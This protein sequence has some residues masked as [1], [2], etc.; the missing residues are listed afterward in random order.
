MNISSSSL[1]KLYLF[2][3]DAKTFFKLSHS[4]NILQNEFPNIEIEKHNIAAWNEKTDLI[5][6]KKSSRGSTLINAE[7]KVNIS[8]RSKIVTVK[9]DSLDNVINGRSVDYIKY[10]VEGAEAE[11]LEGS[12]KTILAHSPILCISLYHRPGDIFRIPLM[13]SAKYPFYRFYLRRKR[14]LPLWEIN[15]YAVPQNKYI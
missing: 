3:P 6:S 12:S 4:C 9:A 1:K 10:D 14:C 7:S 13:L 8:E 5:F 2:E 15:L 11:A